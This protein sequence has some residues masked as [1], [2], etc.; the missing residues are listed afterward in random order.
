MNCNVG[1]LD[2][3]IGVDITNIAKW[4]QLLQSRTVHRPKLHQGTDRKS[5]A[6]T[7]FS[8]LPIWH[9]S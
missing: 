4:G 6:F 5:I 8:L 3:K 9:K 1:Q 7:Q 2:K